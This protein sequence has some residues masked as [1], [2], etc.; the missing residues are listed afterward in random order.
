MNITT[1]III[2]LL[3]VL[4][5]V[6]IGVARL[7]ASRNRLSSRIR[8]I[9]DKLVE[10]SGDASVGRRLD[11]DDDADTAELARTIN[12]LFD[13]LSE[14]DRKIED[15]D[16]LFRD[17]A[18]TLPEIVLIHNEKILFANDSAASLIGVQPTQLA[19]RDVVDLVKPAYRALVRKSVARRL[20]GEEVP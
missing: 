18:R 9:R 19:G 2:A 7:V 20:A 13:A 17:F 12:K 8:S 1:I 15:R 14:R 5:V 10:V 16:K 4:L 11:V 3:S 6:L